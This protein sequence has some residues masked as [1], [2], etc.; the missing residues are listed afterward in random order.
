MKNND[1]DIKVKMASS[2]ASIAET[3]PENCDLQ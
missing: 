3:L 2:L 1:I